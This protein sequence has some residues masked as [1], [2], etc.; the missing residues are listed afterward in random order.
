MSL[1]WLI[2]IAIQVFFIVHVF[3]RGREYW[4]ILIILIFPYVGS[5]VYFF[6]EY[7]PDMQQNPNMRKKGDQLGKM[8]NPKKE[9]NRLQREL[10]ISNS[11]KNKKL[12]ADAYKE[13]GMYDEAI[14]L[15]QNCLQGIYENDASTLEGLGFAHFSKG[16]FEEAKKYLTTLREVHGERHSQEANL[17]LARTLEELGETE[18][19][20]KSYEDCVKGYSG[21][22]ARYR[23]AMF[24]KK[25][26]KVE[27][28]REI[29]FKILNEASLAPKYYR[30]AQKK[31]LDLSKREL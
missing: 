14:P 28:A 4:W 1:L 22:E 26:G 27:E 12:L 13:A 30:K 25:T 8:I 5:L 18:D 16:E 20:L 17:L 23:Y 21:D 31:W 3:K 6:V 9:I 2:S 7:L 19:A 15:Y 24:L 11:F 10:Q 29:F